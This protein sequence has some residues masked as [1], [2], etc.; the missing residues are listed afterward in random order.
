[1]NP[2]WDETVAFGEDVPET[3]GETDMSREEVPAVS[4]EEDEPEWNLQTLL[5]STEPD[6]GRVPE[7]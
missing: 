4:S 5:G 2:K 1:M 6:G 3:S 7:G